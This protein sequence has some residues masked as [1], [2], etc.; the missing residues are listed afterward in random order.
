M[1]DSIKIIV[2]LHIPPPTTIK[3]VRRFLGSIGYYRKYIKN[4][5]AIATPIDDLTKKK[6]SFC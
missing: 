5:A 4:Y 2:L 3:E 6:W 1:V